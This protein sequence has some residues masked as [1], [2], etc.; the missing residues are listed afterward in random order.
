MRK[1]CVILIVFCIFLALF[2]PF[3]S[4]YDPNLI[5]LNKAKLSP[6]LEHFFGTDMLGRDIYTRIL[7][8]LRI[9]LFVGFFSAM[10][11]VF[12]AFCYAFFTRF[13]AYTFFARM[14]DMLLAMPSLL[15]IMFF[16]SFLNGGII[17]MSF[18]IAL[19]HFAFVA[20][21]LDIQISKFQKLEFYQNA[22][23]L[24]STKFRALFKEIFPACLNVLFVLFVLNIAHAI[25]NEATLSF[26]G[27]G[28][29]LA[30]PS[31]GNMLGEASK[32]LFLGIWWM[33]VFP[34][35]F[36]L[37]LILPLFALGNLMQEESKI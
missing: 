10:L 15:V 25:S 33:L 16:Q 36:M 32:G 31:L 13:F 21:V 8:S 9:S 23:V 24:G 26:F 37:L 7:Y 18:V 11:S 2:A 19:G 29:D 17:T 28:V 30:K 35:A 5:D 14:L 1:L 6:N 3:L 20:R 12:F 27:L 22:I 34:V 4:P